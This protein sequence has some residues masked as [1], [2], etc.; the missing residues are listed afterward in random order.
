[1]FPILNDRDFLERN[2]M[3]EKIK[4]SWSKATKSA[5]KCNANKKSDRNYSNIMLEMTEKRL[6]LLYILHSVRIENIQK[7]GLKKNRFFD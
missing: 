1:M 3:I 6:I 7:I 2:I 4:K 5:Q